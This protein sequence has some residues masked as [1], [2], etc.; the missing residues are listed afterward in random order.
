MLLTKINDLYN[1][2][3]VAFKNGVMQPGSIN[4]CKYI[5]MV[6]LTEYPADAPDRIEAFI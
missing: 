4:N 3:Q 2:F 1:F 6:G 5:S